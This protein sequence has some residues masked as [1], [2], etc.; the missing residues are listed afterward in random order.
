MSNVQALVCHP[1]SLFHRSDSKSSLNIGVRPIRPMY[2]GVVRMEM[3]NINGNHSPN[4][5]ARRSRPQH[6]VNGTGNKTASKGTYLFFIFWYYVLHTNQKNV[7]LLCETLLTSVI[8]RKLGESKGT[9]IRSMW[10]IPCGP[11]MTDFT[12][13]GF[14]GGFPDNPSLTDLTL[15]LFLT[16]CSVILIVIQ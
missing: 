5:A 12:E 8:S 4:M 13:I 14:S 10:G 1:R 3:H 6:L 11:S 16:N 15:W 7:K 9:S 2:A